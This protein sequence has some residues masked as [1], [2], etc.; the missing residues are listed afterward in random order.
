MHIHRSVDPNLL[1]MQKLISIP[2]PT[3]L[4]FK[5]RL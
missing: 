4:N 3:F 1:Q 5:A 2:I